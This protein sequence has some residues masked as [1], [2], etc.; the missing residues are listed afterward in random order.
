MHQPDILMMVKECLSV[1]CEY[2][3]PD[4]TVIFS[5]GLINCVQMDSV[6]MTVIQIEIFLLFLLSKAVFVDLE[7]DFHARV[8]VVICK[9]K[10][11][12]I[13]HIF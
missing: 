9:E 13:F 1:S 10:S 12:C 3:F 2:S 8:P 11:R 7:A 4:L 6:V 5:Q